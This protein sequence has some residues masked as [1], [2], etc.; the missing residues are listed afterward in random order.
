MKKFGVIF[1]LVLVFILA[2][3]SFGLAEMNSQNVRERAEVR[4]ETA[5]YRQHNGECTEE[6]L[7]LRVRENKNRSLQREEGAHGDYQ[8]RSERRHQ[9]K[10]GG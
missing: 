9:H 3:S 5:Q 6:G 2:A 4:T 8:Q 1:S 7:Q 10:F